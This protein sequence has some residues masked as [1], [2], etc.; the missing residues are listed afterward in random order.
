MKTQPMISNAPAAEP[1]KK[2]APPR[3]AVRTCN[4]ED[5]LRLLGAPQLKDMKAASLSLV[6]SREKDTQLTLNVQLQQGHY[7][8]VAV[9]D[10]PDFGA[11]N[12]EW[13]RLQF[14][15]AEQGIRLI[16]LVSSRDHASWYAAGDFAAV[17]RR[18]N[19]V[20][21]GPFPGLTETKTPAYDPSV[22]TLLAAAEAGG[23]LN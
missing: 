6:L 8:M 17:S 3:K 20:A 18:R 15:L 2:A 16:P 14:R 23:R 19:G 10:R 5:F 4:Q 7:E 21:H 9:L 1:A 11:R 13:E 12:A 22:L